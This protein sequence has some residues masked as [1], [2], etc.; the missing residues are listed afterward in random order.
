MPQESTF[1]NALRV[2]GRGTVID[3]D[4]NA[5][6]NLQ[7]ED[8]PLTVPAGVTIRGGRNASQ[9]G[10]EV[11]WGKRRHNQKFPSVTDFARRLRVEKVTG[12]RAK[13]IFKMEP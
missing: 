7:Y 8:V 10:A 1:G 2:A 13:P 9:A 6:I 11:F 12:K 5:A 3:I 4:P